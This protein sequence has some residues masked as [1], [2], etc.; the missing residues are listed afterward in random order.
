MEP[1]ISIKMVSISILFTFLTQELVCG[2]KKKSHLFFIP[3]QQLLEI[4]CPHL[5][6]HRNLHPETQPPT[7][8]TWVC[9]IMV[10]LEAAPHLLLQVPSHVSE[11]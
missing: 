8:R 9:L 3:I 11:T 4:D 10:L 6:P 5:K 1:F 7:L 2:T